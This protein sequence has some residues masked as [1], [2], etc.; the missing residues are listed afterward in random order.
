MWQIREGTRADIDAFNAL[1]ALTSNRQEFGVHVSSYYERFYDLFIA[2]DS[3]AKAAVLMASHQDSETGENK[4]LAGVIVISFAGQSWYL[5]G[6]SSHEERNLRASFGVQWAAIQW[7]KANGAKTYDMVGVPDEEITFL[8]AKFENRSDGLWGVY[9]FKRGFGGKVVRTV[10][11]W[12]RVYNPTIYR[13]Y[14]L[15]LFVQDMRAA[16]RKR[17]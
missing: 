11:A 17:E 16:N 4:D 3:P 12:D 13:M 7:A 1:L 10:G 14:R 15:Y 2:G 6:A 9:R 8:E 5:Y